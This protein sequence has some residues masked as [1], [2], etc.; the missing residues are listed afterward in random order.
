[1]KTLIAASLSALTLLAI[2]ASAQT[3]STMLPTLTWPEGEV[4]VSTKG[5]APETVCTPQ[6]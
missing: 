5:C 6:K 2:P 1:M 4:T 3:L